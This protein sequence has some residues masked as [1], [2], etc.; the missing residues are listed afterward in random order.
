MSA[1]DNNTL[2]DKIILSTTSKQRDLR[3]DMQKQ[4]NAIVLTSRVVFLH[5]GVEFM[6]SKPKVGGGY[7]ENSYESPIPPINYV[8]I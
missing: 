2:Y 7:D 5:A 3:D 8:G 6:R 4:A 1:H